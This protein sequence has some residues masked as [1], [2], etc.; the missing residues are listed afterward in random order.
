MHILVIASAESLWTKKYIERVLLPGGHTVTLLSQQFPIVKDFYDAHGI[1]VI[2]LAPQPRFVGQAGGSGATAHIS[3]SKR[4]YLAIKKTLPARLKK[5]IRQARMRRVVAVATKGIPAPDAIHMHYIN[6]D[7]EEVY[8][9]TWMN[10]S[11]PLILTYWGSD[12]LRLT[13]KPYNQSLLA[14][15]SA[16]TFMAEGLQ[17]AFRRVYGVKYDNKL[18]IIDFGVSVYDAID[19]LDRSAA[20]HEA[21]RQHF[22]IPTGKVCI[23]AGYNANPGQQHLPMIE[24]IDRLPNASK[25]NIHVLLQYSYNYTE[26]PEY[27]ASIAKRLENVGFS[28]TI[29]DIFMDD[30]ES[31]RLRDAVDIFIHGQV[32]DALSASMLEYLYAGALVVNGKW[33]VYRE[34]ESRGIFYM[35]FDTFEHLT[36]LLADILA[37]ESRASFDAATNRAALYAMNSWDAVREKWLQI[38]V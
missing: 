15:A 20:A 21:N 23:M 25:L 31:A 32:T 5:Y 17:E 37:A 28:W 9:H 13:G 10:F 35:Q 34:L 22:G 29:I 2:A 14:K 6:P 33:L 38:Y 8:A 36:F 12:I 4:I 16:I 30:M 19:G 11:G 3:L 1:Q 26:S 27:Y 7:M 24:A 18:R